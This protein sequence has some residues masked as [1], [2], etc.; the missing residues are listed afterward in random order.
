MFEVVDWG[1]RDYGPALS[2]M[3]ALRRARRK[4]TIPDT[5]ILLE[6]PAVITVGV[7]GDDGGAEQAG[8]PVFRVE[9]GGKST[10]HAPGQLVG[11][12]LVDLARRGND[13]RRFVAD[14]ERL[15]VTVL[16]GYGVPAGTVPSRRGVW[17]GGER[18]IAS[19][20]IA[21]EEW[22]TF[23]GFALNV[24]LDLA[25]FERFR[26]CGMEGV[27][28][29]SMARELGV[30]VAVADVKRRVAQLWL[31]DFLSPSPY[32]SFPAAV[33]TPAVAAPSNP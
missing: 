23:H 19:I 2:A 12:P 25:P 22:V 15:L 16:R 1:L 31:A 28:M 13:V 7:Q 27:V 14:L 3:R 17:V 6:H 5:L 9:R 20:G 10:Y 26:P 30:P 33:P 8:V 32:A 21:V 4:G 18:K 24:D 29:T 11:Y